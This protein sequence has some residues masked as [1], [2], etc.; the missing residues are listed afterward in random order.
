M[1]YCFLIY[2]VCAN[3]QIF[4]CGFEN[5][6]SLPSGLGE[7]YR[8]SG[9][10]NPSSDGQATP[11][12]FHSMGGA[13]CDLPE[14]PYAMLQAKEGKA[15]MGIEVVGPVESS[16]REY[17]TL[18]LDAPLQVGKNYEFQMVSFHPFLILVWPS[19][20]WAFFSRSS[21]PSRQEPIQS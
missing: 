15:V 4:Q 14:T 16:Q 10:S 19:M 11:D 21:Y 5:Y 1:T 18:V 12:Y 17:L 9:V 13:A 8:I 3:S 20:E 6:L 2:A 7:W